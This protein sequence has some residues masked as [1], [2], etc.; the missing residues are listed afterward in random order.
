MNRFDPELWLGRLTL[1]VV[2]FLL[3][4][5]LVQAV[6]GVIWGEAN[7]VVSRSAMALLPGESRAWSLA[8]IGLILGL[9]G[10]WWQKERVPNAVWLVRVSIA[11]MICGTVSCVGMVLTRA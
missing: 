5:L 11:T 3:G 4:G 8:K 7:M 10:L 6:L 9:L 2:L 1:A